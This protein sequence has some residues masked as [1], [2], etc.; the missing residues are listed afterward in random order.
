MVNFANNTFGDPAHFWLGVTN[1]QE[2]LDHV[3]FETNPFLGRIHWEILAP[4]EKGMHSSMYAWP[5]DD[6][7]RWTSPLLFGKEDLAVE[8]TR[9]AD[10]TFA[11]TGEAR[12]DGSRFDYDYD[13][14]VKWFRNLKITNEGGS[15]SLQAT[16]L[17]HADGGSTGTYYFLRGRD[18]VNS[19]GGSTGVE[20]TFVVKDEGATSIAFLLDVRT[21]GP[22]AIEFVDP[23]GTVWHREALALGG[24]SD[25]LVE[26]SK[27]PPAGTWK[28][29]Y[30]GNVQGDILVRGIIE[31][32]ATF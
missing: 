24:S 10:G 19:Q 4:H 28:L 18:Y 25:K 1:R 15:T 30:V 12:A 13:P 7:S 31:Y 2:A 3:F 23:A 8:A 32:K 27:S 21:T 16:V 6:G 17:D 26:V 22:S 5:L 11:I 29:R 14:S 20:T 9:N